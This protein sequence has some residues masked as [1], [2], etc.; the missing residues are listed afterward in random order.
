MTTSNNKRDFLLRD[1]VH[2]VNWVD[3]S[4]QNKIEKA[5]WE[6][7]P[8]TKSMI[9][10]N[11]SD[12]ITRSVDLA[13]VLGISRQAIHQTLSEMVHDNLLEMKPDPEDGRAKIVEISPK[14]QD[15]RD[16]AIKANR[17]IEKEL[18]KRIGKGNVANLI[19]ALHKDWGSPLDSQ[20]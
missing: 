14:A 12:G 9:L 3:E 13:K 17:A 8:R 11:V 20:E 4:L 6:R 10:T 16:A 7:M 2:A 18:A 19:K 1:L 15:I 5:G